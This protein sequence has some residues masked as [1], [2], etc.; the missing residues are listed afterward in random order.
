M[1]TASPRKERVVQRLALLLVGIVGFFDSTAFFSPASS[2][3]PEMAA[4][5]HDPRARDAHYGSPL[6]AAQYL[7]D[8]HDQSAVFNFCGSLMFQL[9]LSPK[10]RDHLAHVAQEKPEGG[11]QPV[12]YDA[13][14][15]RLMKVQGY[16]KTAN[17]DNICVF[18]GREVR[19]VPGAAGG[20]GCVLHLSLANEA[21]PEGWTKEEIGD[22]NGWAPDSR[23]PWRRGEQL[24]REGFEGFKKKFGES[25]YGLH[26]RFYLHFD[27]RNAMWLSAEDGCEGEPWPSR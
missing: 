6:N 25:S 7:V 27:R 11:K 26:H 15:D 9:C 14:H 3:V 23:R 16:S 19:D 18:H 22:Y 24:E 12:I 21:D 5:L 1:S 8:M 13:S 10:L 20:Q 4:H 17:A 2:R